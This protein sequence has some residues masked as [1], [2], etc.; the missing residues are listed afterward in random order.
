MIRMAYNINNSDKN[1]RKFFMN[2][3]I[4]YNKAKKWKQVD[5]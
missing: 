3:F 5:F 1:K 4:V 2:K